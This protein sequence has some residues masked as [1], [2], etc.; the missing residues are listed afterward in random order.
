MILEIPKLGIRLRD[1]VFSCLST[2][3]TG[4][5]LIQNEED[6]GLTT[7]L[8]IDID[9]PIALNGSPKDLLFVKGGNSRKVMQEA[10]QIPENTDKVMNDN[11]GDFHVQEMLKLA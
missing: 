10:S 5:D 1:D 2:C 8:H 9:T 11:T 7:R 4:F 6:C 3:S